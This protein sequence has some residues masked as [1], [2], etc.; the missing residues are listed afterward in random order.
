VGWS[1]EQPLEAME[2]AAG[3]VTF[4]ETKVDVREV[5]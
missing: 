3:H 2:K 5:A 4:D 1:Y